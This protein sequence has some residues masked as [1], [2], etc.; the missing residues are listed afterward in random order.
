ATIDQATDKATIRQTVEKANN[1]I[2]TVETGAETAFEKTA[3]R[4]AVK[5][6]A[7]KI[8]AGLNKQED[9]D[10]VDALSAQANKD[11]DAAAGVAAVDQAR[12]K[13]IQAIDNVKSTADATVAK[14]LQDAKNQAIGE[15]HDKQVSVKGTIDGLPNISSDVKTKL[16]AKVDAEYQAA[17]TGVAN[18]QT[19]GDVTNAKTSGLEKMDAVLTEAKGLNASHAASGGGGM[20]V[21]PAPDKDD[22]KPNH[23]QPAATAHKVKNVV[24]MHN[25][26]LYDETGKCANK[27]TL[28][29]GSSLVTYGTEVLNGRQYYVLVD[30]G[31]DNKKYYVA[32]GNAEAIKQP[33]KHNAYVYNK[34]GKRIKRLGTLHKGAMVNTYGAPVKIRGHKYFITANNRFIKAAN[35]DLIASKAM[36]AGVVEPISAITSAKPVATVEKRIM[37]NAYLYNEKGERSN[38]L[39]IAAGSAVNTTGTRAINGRAYYALENGTYIATGNVDGQ[40]LRLRHNAY[41]YS[42]YGNRL[43]RQVLKRHR[44]LKV[45][46]D[47]VTIK[48]RKYYTVAKNMYVKTANFR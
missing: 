34:Y 8:K 36:G 44:S 38:G 41:I 40:N 22:N 42:Q 15:L 32:I 27:I 14:D 5:A 23:T 37:H 20:I 10:K 43:G 24:L 4:D 35:V 3:A 12:D 13:A 9:K 39:I 30:Q 33:L 16:K 28:K 18:A 48:G 29:A 7:N 26:Y 25:A 21:V 45:Y 11:I 31:A 6:E 19:L 47:P 17:A 2:T 1:D 46:G